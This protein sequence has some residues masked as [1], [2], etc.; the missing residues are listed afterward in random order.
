MLIR[1]KNIKISYRK[2]YDLMAGVDIFQLCF[3]TYEFSIDFEK[4]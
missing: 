3:G 2:E 1:K 4:N